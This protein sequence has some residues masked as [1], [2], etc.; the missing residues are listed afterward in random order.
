MR[1]PPELR[2]EASSMVLCA[3][4]SCGDQQAFAL[5]LHVCRL[6]SWI[7]E[8]NGGQ[9]IQGLY[10]GQEYRTGFVITCQRFWKGLVLSFPVS[11]Y[12]QISYDGQN[13]FK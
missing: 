13:S 10:C 7:T 1:I 2:A 3:R 6:E 5:K 11:V 12:R 9:M 4:R 8:V